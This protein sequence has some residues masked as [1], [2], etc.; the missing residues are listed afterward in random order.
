MRIRQRL[1]REDGAAA[2]E[3]ALIVGVLAMLIFGMLEFGVAFFTLQ[4]LRSSTREGARYAAVGATVAQS[5]QRVEDSAGVSGLA[6]AVV[7][8]R[9]T[10]SGGSTWFPDG[11]A[12]DKPCQIIAGQ[13]KPTSVRTRIDLAGASLPSNLVDIFTLNIP[14]L[15]PISLRSATVQGDFRCEGA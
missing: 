10:A 4:S 9:Q 15:P 11:V 12:L 6:A 2:V 8:E 3:F 14:L 7:V 1:A 13:P 5:Q